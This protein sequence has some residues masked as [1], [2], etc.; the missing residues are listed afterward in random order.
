MLPGPTSCGY[1]FPC[2]TG[3]Q[4]THWGRQILKADLVIAIGQ[5]MDKDE[6]DISL[7]SRFTLDEAVTGIVSQ[8]QALG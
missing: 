4:A 2:R 7:S 1:V 6:A 8:A 3:G 5:V